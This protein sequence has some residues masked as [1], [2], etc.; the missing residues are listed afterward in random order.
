MWYADS[1]RA[2]AR[3]FA[4]AVAAFLMV[5]GS[6]AQAQIPCLYESGG[7]LASWYSECEDSAS[8]ASALGSG[9]SAI[10]EG[11]ASQQINV[12]AGIAG[13]ASPTGRLRH[14]SHD[15]L[16]EKST[17]LRTQGF[18]IDEGS[19][20][21]NVSYDLP[22]TYFGGKVRVNGLAG[23]NRLSQDIDTS[24]AKTDI[25]AFIYGGS[26]LWSKG[27]FYSMSLIIGLSGEADG[28]E[29]TVGSKYSYDVS[30]YF[31]NS[32]IGYTFDWPGT[33]WRFDLRGGLGHYD[34][35]TDSFT[36]VNNPAAGKIKGVAEAWSGSITGTLFTLVE[37]DG[38]GVLRPYVL[39]SY[40][41]VFDEEIEV[42]GD[43]VAEFE[44]A[45]DFGKVELGFDYVKGAL[46]YGAAAYTEF[47]EDEKTIGARLGVSVKLQ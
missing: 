39:A 24:G 9:L 45:D 44:Q 27:S 20:F 36:F 2:P 41:N 7:F 28:V 26:Y 25:D 18:E 40:K 30:G 37:T 31:T 16:V 6:S 42:K 10:G 19:V 33:G 43:F 11:F 35:S 8:S 3:L 21:G 1:L 38:G 47:S 22:G 14:T 13:F 12:G 34:V 29:S 17:G 23:Y 4:L 32:V 46:T 5:P 15:G